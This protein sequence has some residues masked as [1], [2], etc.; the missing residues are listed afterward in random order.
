MPTHSVGR[1]GTPTHSVGRAGTPTHSVGLRSPGDSGR[2]SHDDGSDQMPIPDKEVQ[3]PLLIR[4]GV[5]GTTVYPD[6]SEGM[7]KINQGYG[8]LLHCFPLQY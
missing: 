4:P 7:L 1:A 8:L 2:V 3:E 6:A 5:W